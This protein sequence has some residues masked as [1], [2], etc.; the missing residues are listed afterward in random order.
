VKSVKYVG[1][2]DVPSFRHENRNISPAAT[3]K[4]DYICEALVEAGYHVQIVSGSET[5]TKEWVYFPGRSEAI[6]TAKTVTVGPTFSS[7][8]K[9]VRGCA[10]V[11]NGAW[12]TWWLL[13]HTRRG[14]TLLVY[15]VPHVFIPLWVTKVVKRC[16]VVLEVEE[17][18]QDVAPIGRFLTTSETRQIALADGYLFSSDLLAER[19]GIDASVKPF[20]I[21]YGVYRSEPKLTT[22]EEDCRV[23]LVYAGI[24]DEVKRGAINAVL[25][26]GFLDSKFC[27]H[28]IGFGAESSV[29]KLKDLIQDVNGKGGCQVVFD[30]KKMGEDYIRYVQGCHIGLSTQAMDGQYLTSSF[31][32]KILSYC[33]LGLPVVSCA[34]ECVERSEIGHLVT[35]YT[36]DTP[37]AIA[38]AIRRVDLG[39]ASE[40]P[41]VMRL[42]HSRFVLAVAA[43]IEGRSPGSPKTSV[44]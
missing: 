9:L 16:R 6:G 14:E 25:A 36:E 15:H 3:D 10:L 24:I 43:L 29:A 40:I 32:S 33:T 38:D 39:S 2:Y 7:R 42:L 23:H 13:S 35:F 18:Y 4:M 27:L 28:V 31:P 44:P 20:T 19:L 21:I 8:N 26:A 34:A 30:G 17:I 5:R 11:A 22:A 41:N 37:E 12:L 1:Y